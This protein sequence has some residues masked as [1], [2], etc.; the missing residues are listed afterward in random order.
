MIIKVKQVIIREKDLSKLWGGSI[1]SLAIKAGIGYSTLFKA[2]KDRVLSQEQWEK[3]EP[4][5]KPFKA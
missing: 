3:I 1:R 5:L 4:Y 2:G